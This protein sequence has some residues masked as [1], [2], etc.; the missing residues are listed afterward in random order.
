MHN[1]RLFVLFAALLIAVGCSTPRRAP[2]TISVLTYNIHHAEGMDKKLDVERIAGVI[3]ATGADLV[4]IQEVDQG[5]TRTNRLDTPA[6]LGR[7]TKMHY[8]YGPAMEYQGGKYGNLVLSRWPIESKTV[9]A[10]PGSGGVHEPRSV[11]AAVCVAQG[12]QIVFAST[13]LDFTKEPSDRLR[14]AKVIVAAFE[15]ERRPMILAGDFNCEIGSPPLAL[16]EKLW[17]NASASNSEKTCPAD[18]PKVKIDHVLVRPAEH[19]RVVEVR[20]IPE[21]VASDHRPVLVTLERA[22]MPS[23]H[24]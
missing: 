8:A 3:R 20:V 12:E 16:L 5:T 7:L 18:V 9:T 1:T 23:R 22:G 13:H 14:Q 19:W 21:V 11:V 2:Q 6:E 24:R 10:L 15:N 4:A 17:S